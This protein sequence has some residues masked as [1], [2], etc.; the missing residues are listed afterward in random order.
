MSPIKPPRKPPQDGKLRS[1]TATI[2]K[3]VFTCFFCDASGHRASG[4]PI[5]PT[6]PSRLSRCRELN[7][8]LLCL[9]HHPGLCFRH[10][11]K[12]PN[13][14]GQHHAA[15][16]GGGSRRQH[17]AQ[18]TA[19]SPGRESHKESGSGKSGRVKPVK[20]QRDDRSIKVDSPTT[21]RQESP[22]NDCALK[23]LK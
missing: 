18:P 15:L 17:P 12:C 14:D 22:G 5:Y 3:P 20:V 9:R 1:P 4:C 8:C 10:E 21:E 13:C 16:C 11:W 23:C 19:A 7:Y 6:A 2:V